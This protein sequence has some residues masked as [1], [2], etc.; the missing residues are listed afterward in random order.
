MLINAPASVIQSLKGEGL[1]IAT[2]LE[3]GEKFDAVQLFVLSKQELM[4]YAYRAVKV[5][6]PSGIL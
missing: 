2:E 4:E 6:N 5:L 1:Q 3:E